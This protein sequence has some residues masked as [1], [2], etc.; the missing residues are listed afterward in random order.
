MLGENEWGKNYK[1]IKEIF[2]LYEKMTVP[3]YTW[4]KTNKWQLFAMALLK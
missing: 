2:V 4:L 3:L 1:A